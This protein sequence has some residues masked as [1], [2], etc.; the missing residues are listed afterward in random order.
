MD[1]SPRPQPHRI[2]QL[3]DACERLSKTMVALTNAEQD[4]VRAALL[5]QVAAC[6]AR[7]AALGVTADA[8]DRIEAADRLYF[9]DTGLY[10]ETMASRLFAVTEGDVPTQR[11]FRALVGEHAE[12]EVRTGTLED[13][14]HTEHGA[15]ASAQA[16]IQRYK[17]VVSVL[18]TTAIA[19]SALQNVRG[20][21]QP[22]ARPGHPQGT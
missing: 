11:Q 18:T 12:G 3:R 21:L 15:P 5:E 9:L 22:S 20:P 6:R 17:R 2:E 14:L 16:V 7:L 4:D 1:H 8:A 13:V 10:A 19:L